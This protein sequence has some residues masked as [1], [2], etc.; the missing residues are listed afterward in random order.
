M[1]AINGGFYL[2]TTTGRMPT[3]GS[4]RGLQIVEG[5]VLSA[6]SDNV[7]LWFDYA[8][9]PHA[10]IVTSQFEIIWPDGRETPFGLN[11]QRA[12]S[13]IELYTPAAGTSTHTVGGRELVL[14][15]PAGGRWLPLRMERDCPARLRE[16]RT[17]G[18]RPYLLTRLCCPSARPS[19]KNLKP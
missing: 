4:P 1:A 7:S 15:A 17:A 6:P 14:E 8:G 10:A 2:R 5:E 19:R 16:I 9:Q 12:D 18:T 3:A 11:G 13:G